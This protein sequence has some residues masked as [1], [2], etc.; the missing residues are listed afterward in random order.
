VID[1]LDLARRLI[2]CASVTPADDGAQQVLKDALAP[3]GFACRDLPFGDIRNLYAR[4]G[5]E[6]PHFCFCG[7]TDVVP[8]GDEGAWRHDPFA[9]VVHEG[10]LYGRGAADMKANIAC[11]VAAV[12]RF[13]DRHGNPPGSVSLL[14][15][16]DE[17]ADALD[18]TV[19]V[20]EWME[21]N[22]ELPDAALVGEPSN[23]VAI[24]D[25]IRIGR[26]GSLT[27]RLTVRGRQGHTAWPQLADNPLPRLIKLCDALAEYEF[28]TGSGPFPATNLQI[29]SIDVGN[30]ASNVIPAS[31]TAL[32]N[33]RFNDKWTAQ[34][35]DRKL[36]EI[37]GAVHGTYE[38]ETHSNA[39]SF[40]T[41]ADNPLS[42]L[43]AAAVQDVTGRTPQMTTSGGTSDAR[44]V[45]KYCPV[46]ECGLV[47]ETMHQV[48]ENV[49]LED[50]AQLTDVYE[51]VLVRYFGV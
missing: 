3:M 50:M 2:R 49:S 33:I 18:G 34:S 48:D 12:S 13:R 19:R 44:F 41:P 37:L 21:G 29:S 30:R 39:A 16:G 26:R 36:R 15:T 5:G 1:A 11:F 32:F 51:R 25:E 27:G 42:R 24:G 17:E 10:R 9:A 28:D 46:V 6:G 4:L 35:L 7:H 14:I 40:I 20:L 45:Q 43:V 22:G 31:G 38:L 47:L 8:P 23:P